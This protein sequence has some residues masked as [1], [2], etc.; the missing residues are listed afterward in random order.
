MQ[1]NFT[2]KLNHML[3]KTIISCAMIGAVALAVASSGGGDK[4][5]GSSLR[6]S[7]FTPIRTTNGFTL[8]AGPSYTG[9]HLFSSARNS[10]SVTLNSVVTYQQ[11][12]KVFILPHKSRVIINTGNSASRTN[13]NALDVKFRLRK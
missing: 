12:N 9:S 4:K 6:N 1:A 3:K 2:L 5:K 13:L 11:G 10:N 8:K 7:D